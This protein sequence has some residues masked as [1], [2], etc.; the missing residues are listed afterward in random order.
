MA[1]SSESLI[2]YMHDKLGLTSTVDEH[3]PLF[4][5]NLLDS[6]TMVD[7]ISFVESQAGFRM[8]VWDVSLDNLD[9]ISRILNYVRSKMPG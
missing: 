2:Q 3:T 6:F 5:S 9:S 4:S 7:L 1:L 8:D